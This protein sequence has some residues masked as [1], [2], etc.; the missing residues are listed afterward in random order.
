[1]PSVAHPEVLA[2]DWLPPT[3]VGRADELAELR[4]LL[5]DPLPD[6]PMPWAA[7]VRGPSGSGTSAT[8]RLA[9]RRLVEAYRRE[10][11]NATAPLLVAV[12]VRWCA[13]SHGVATALLQSLD[14]GFSGRGFPVVEIV[15]GFLRRLGRLGCP[16]IVVLDDVGPDTPDLSPILR[17]LLHPLRFLPEGV[18]AA[19]PIWTIVAG[20]MDRSGP[21]AGRRPLGIPGDA[22]LTLPAMDPV[23]VRGIIEDRVGRALGRS[24]PEGLVD[25]L[26]LRSVEGSLGATRA[27][28]LVRRELLGP[29]AGRLTPTL[30]PKGAPS[31]ISVEPRIV[32]ALALAGDGRL[33]PLSEVRE[34]EAKLARA[35]GV[36]PLPATTLWRR[37]IHLEAAGLVRREVRPGGPGGTRSRLELLRPVTEWPVPHPADR[38]HRSAGVS[39]SSQGPPGWASGDPVPPGSGSAGGPAAGRSS[40]PAPG[41]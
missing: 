16:A 20:D 29:T 13:G 34:W 17:G 8:A 4:E 30:G 28:D 27:L 41:T 14:D 26:V 2:H 32:E 11:P 23:T 9:A 36:R 39:R 35:E 31:M 19:P 5:G 25:R 37:L 22:Q 15:A 3:L 18:D 12:R 1:M 38:T 6:R 10:R 24:P 33:V 21:W 7:T 40:R